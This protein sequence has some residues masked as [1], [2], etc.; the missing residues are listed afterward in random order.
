[1]TA[2]QVVLVIA[3]VG[4]LVYFLVRCRRAFYRMGVESRA[5]QASIEAAM[6]AEE[7]SRSHRPGTG[8]RTDRDRFHEGERARPDFMPLPAPPY[9]PPMMPG[10][11]KKP[12]DPSSESGP[13]YF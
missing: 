9:M 1:M 5:T 12:D 7:R 13:S 6:R 3:V 10:S 8:Q 4:A 2:A 11:A